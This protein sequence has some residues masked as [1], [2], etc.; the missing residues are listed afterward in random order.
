MVR[1]K[2]DK[3]TQGY[4]VAIMQLISL[5][6]EDS[7]ALDL[8]ICAGFTYDQFVND[9][10]APDDLQVIKKAWEKSG[11]TKKQPPP[12]SGKG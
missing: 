7:M 6:G 8:M 10:V 4:A 12:R 11:R 9:G 2:Q 3:F 5:H 1:K